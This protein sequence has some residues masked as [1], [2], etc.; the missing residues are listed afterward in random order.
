MTTLAKLM[1]CHLGIGNLIS[2]IFLLTNS[3]ASFDRLGSKDTLTPKCF[4]L[5]NNKV[6]LLSLQQAHDY[7][8]TKEAFLL[9]GVV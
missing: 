5:F 9:G 8:W 3:Y 7:V 1:F 2:G 6:I 4:E